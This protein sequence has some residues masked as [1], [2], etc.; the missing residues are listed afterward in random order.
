MHVYRSRSDILYPHLLLADLVN[1]DVS[2]A[3]SIILSNASRISPVVGRILTELTTAMNQLHEDGTGTEA[4]ILDILKRFFAHQ[5]LLQMKNELP[6]TAVSEEVTAC[7]AEGII[8][9]PLAST[10]DDISKKLAEQLKTVFDIRNIVIDLYFLAED[11]ELESIPF[12]ECIRAYAELHY[13]QIC[14]PLPGYAE[15]QPCNNVCRNVMIGC[16]G[17]LQQ[18]REALKAMASKALAKLEVVQMNANGYQQ[19]IDRLGLELQ[20]LADSVE[21][22]GSNIIA[23][24]C[25]RASSIA[26]VTTWSYHRSSVTGNLVR[27]H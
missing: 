15:S 9:E 10:L 14:V 6:S 1:T 18:F 8:P 27:C 5:I 7:A 19:T 22:Q 12:T 20:R 4:D 2:K 13:C 26:L 11:L 23:Q 24:V 21:G 16:S 17:F 25:A 3:A